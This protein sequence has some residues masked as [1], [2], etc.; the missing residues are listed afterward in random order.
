MNLPTCSADLELVFAIGGG[1]LL[2]R[3]EPPAAQT[4]AADSAAKKI[5]L[6]IWQVLTLPL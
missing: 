4:A 5:H 6:E 1:L 2:A 3:T